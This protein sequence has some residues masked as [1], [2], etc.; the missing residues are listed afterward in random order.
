MGLIV[1][2]ADDNISAE[3][4]GYFQ[5]LS[6]FWLLVIA[7]VTTTRFIFQVPQDG[8]MITFADVQPLTTILTTNNVLKQIIAPLFNLFHQQHDKCAI[9]ESFSLRSSV[10]QFQHNVLNFIIG[11]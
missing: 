6:R 11:P 5:K 3:V 4:F 1:C 2:K 7:I 9:K 10:K 8:V